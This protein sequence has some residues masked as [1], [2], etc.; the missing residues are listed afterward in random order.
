MSKIAVHN[1]FEEFEGDADSGFL[2]EAARLLRPGGR[3]CIVPFF[4]G[5][6]YCIVTDPTVD[7]HGVQ[8][9]EGAE[10][11]SLSSG[12]RFDRLYDAAAFERRVLQAT[13]GLQ[14]RLHHV[15]NAAQLD[16]FCYVTFV[17]LFEKPNVPPDHRGWEQPT[18]VALP[19]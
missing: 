3:L 8:F 16:P 18:P 2:R 7:R 9:D 13:R 4:L 1:A 19:C 15:L 6:R 17:A 10:V 14:L 12:N 5:D 11:V